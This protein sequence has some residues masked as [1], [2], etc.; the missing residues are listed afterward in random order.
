[1]ASTGPQ[2]LS[3][4]KVFTE[5]L[6]SALP[7]FFLKPLIQLVAECLSVDHVIV[8]GEWVDVC[9]PICVF[10]AEEAPPDLLALPGRWMAMQVT[11]VSESSSSYVCINVIKDFY[12]SHSNDDVKTVD[13]AS[14]SSSAPPLSWLEEGNITWTILVHEL[15][16]LV[17]PHKTHA[18]DRYYELEP[19]PEDNDNGDIGCFRGDTLVVMAD[20]SLRPISRVRPG[21]YV[22]PVCIQQT[23]KHQNGDDDRHECMRQGHEGTRVL[24]VH[25]NNK[26]RVRHMVLHAGIWTTPG[27]PLMI[28]GEWGRSD[29]MGIATLEKVPLV[30]SLSLT[31][32]GHAI[33]AIMVRDPERRHAAVI[34]GTMGLTW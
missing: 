26:K 4:R 20:G 7:Q 22:A 24:R 1:M 12:W 11:A 14:S 16:E 3:C 23:K 15:P 17:A 34:A 19:G 30:Y 6:Q 10:S 31:L 32:A 2:G 33:H 18:G 28:D 27:H 9:I 25:V 21:D 29:A 8:S 5:A 13:A